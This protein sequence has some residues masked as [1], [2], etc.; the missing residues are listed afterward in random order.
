METLT[1]IIAHIQSYMTS[2]DWQYIITFIIICYGI[3]HYKI[4]EGLQKATGTQTRTRYRVI[5]IGV[6]YAVGLYFL[7][8]YKLQQIENL[9]QSFIFALVF[10]K[11]IVE[12]LLYWLAKHALPESISKHILTE[13]Q[14]KKI[15]GNEGK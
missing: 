10:H 15:N 2:L 5:I 14:I 13:E 9:F 12:A 7:R 3:N 6:V 11:F 8:G 4:K 1:E